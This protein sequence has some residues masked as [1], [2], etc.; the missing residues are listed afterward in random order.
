MKL[1]ITTRSIASAEGWFARYGQTKRALLVWAL[2]DDGL[3]GLIQGAGGD[4]RNAEKETVDGQQ[5]TDYVHIS[6]VR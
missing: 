5:L 4:A 6:E 1:N 2:T 3:V